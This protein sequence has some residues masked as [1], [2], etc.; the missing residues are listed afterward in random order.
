M[1]EE[2]KR[3]ETQETMPETPETQ[4]ETPETQPETPEAQ[5][6]TPETQPETPE[7]QPEKPQEKSKKGFLATYIFALLFIALVLVFLSYLSQLRATRAQIENLTEEHNLFSVN[8]LGS[9]D[10][11]TAELEETRTR[12]SEVRAERD[13]LTTERDDTAARLEET[14]TKLDAAEQELIELKEEYADLWNESNELSNRIKA[15]SIATEITEL[16]KA[17]DYESAMELADTFLGSTLEELV[18]TEYPAQYAAYAAAVEVLNE[19]FE[20]E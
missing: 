7:T 15:L 8:A 13:A 20:E 19:N 4:P 3:T 12:L 9:I 16:V 11:L 5:P 18:E 1:N 14:Q 17:E 6:E 10:K 2:E